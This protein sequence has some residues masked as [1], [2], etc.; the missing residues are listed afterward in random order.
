M[1]GSIK[2]NEN[3]VIDAMCIWEALLEDEVQSN[4]NKTDSIYSLQREAVGA[5][6]M[7]QVVLDVLL[8]PL[9]AGWRE[10]HNDFNDCFDWE[11]VPAFL[12]K[13]APY[14]AG[15]EDWSL[16]EDQGVK[17][18]KSLMSDRDARSL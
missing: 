2:F 17:I 14:L 15:L 18:A 13:A 1:T 11:Y 8:A 10:V 9:A 4:K 16:T 7:R 5:F 3:S 6:A 12:A